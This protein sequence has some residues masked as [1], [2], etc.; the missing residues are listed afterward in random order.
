MYKGKLEKIIQTIVIAIA[1]IVLTYIAD[2]FGMAKG[3]VQVRISDAL[4][5]LPYFTPAAIPGLFIGS[6]IS[7]VIISLTE[8]PMTGKMILSSAAQYYVIIESLVILIASIISYF[9]RKFKFVV[10]VPTIV[11]NT[12]TIP[13][14]FHYIYRYEDS[15]AKCIMTVGI[16]E[17]ISCGL[18][19]TALLLALEDSKDKWFPSNDIVSDKHEDEKVESNMDNKS[20]SEEINV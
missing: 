11:I 3:I 1:Y 18:L 8:D 2:M 17:I 7:N 14:I 19:G 5:I 12:I 20:E 13:L 4:C 16:G 10:C 9:L 15:V 6:A